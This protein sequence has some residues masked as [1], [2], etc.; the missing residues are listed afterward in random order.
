MGLVVIRPQS[1]GLAENPEM[2]FNCECHGSVCDLDAI[3]APSILMLIRSRENPFYFFLFIFEK[4]FF[5]FRHVEQGRPV[6]VDC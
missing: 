2:S 5:F 4:S 3:G 1:F 6:F